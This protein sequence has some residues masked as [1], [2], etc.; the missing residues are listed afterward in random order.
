MLRGEAL[1]SVVGF[2]FPPPPP[3]PPPTRVCFSSNHS[4]SAVASPLHHSTRVAYGF[5]ITMRARIGDYVLLETIGSGAFANVRHGIHEVSGKHYAIKVMDKAHIRNHEL[6]LN[7]RRE[8]AIMKALNHP[9]IVALHQV[10]SS[11]TKL[12]IVLDLVQ[13]RELFEIISRQGTNGLP[14]QQA[15]AYFQQLIEAVDYCHSRGV[16]HRD[17]KPENLLIDQI[18]KLKV[19]DFGFSS[20][21]GANTASDLLS[22][23]CGTPHYI[24][25]EIISNAHPTY[26]GQKVDAWACGIILYALLVGYLPFDETDLTYLFR[27]IQRAYVEYP[28]WVSLSARHLIS[29]LLCV[30]PQARLSVHQVKRHPWFLVDYHPPTNPSPRSTPSPRRRRPRV[31]SNADHAAAFSSPLTVPSHPH[32]SRKTDPL[33]ALAPPQLQLPQLELPLASAGV[34]WDAA[35]SS[36]RAVTMARNEMIKSGR[37]MTSARKYSLLRKGVVNYGQLEIGVASFSGPNTLGGEEQARI[38]GILSS[39]TFGSVLGGLS[40]TAHHSSSSIASCDDVSLPVIPYADE[41][42]L[43]YQGT[44]FALEQNLQTPITVSNTTLPPDDE[45]QGNVQQEQDAKRSELVDSTL[46]ALRRLRVGLQKDALRS[47]GEQQASG[48]EKQS[49][50]SAVQTLQSEEM[51]RLLDVWETRIISDTPRTVSDG[52]ALSEEEVR[53]FQSLLRKWETFLNGQ[54]VV[55]DVSIPGSERVEDEV[56]TQSVPDRFKEEH[57]ILSNMD[58]RMRTPEESPSS[59][60]TRNTHHARWSVDTPGSKRS[61]KWNLPDGRDRNSWDCRVESSA[62]PSAKQYDDLTDK[63]NQVLVAN[64]SDLGSVPAKVDIDSVSSTRGLKSFAME[65]EDSPVTDVRSSGDRKHVEFLE[66]STSQVSEVG[67]HGTPNNGNSRHSTCDCGSPKQSTIR[68]VSSRRNKFTRQSVDNGALGRGTNPPSL[69]VLSVSVDAERHESPRHFYRSEG[70]RRIKTEGLPEPTNTDSYGWEP[71]TRSSLDKFFRR[72]SRRSSR[73]ERRLGGGWQIRTR[74]RIFTKL[75]NLQFRSKFEGRFECALG[76]E[77]C[78]RK[79]QKLLDEMGVDVHKKRGQLMLQVDLHHP[80]G[81]VAVAGIFDFQA[82]PNHEE[83]VV[84]FK[85]KDRE[86]VVSRGKEA[87]VLSE[88]FDQALDWFSSSY[89]N[90]LLYP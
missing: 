66:L 70:Q 49:T 80:S 81:N 24:A 51:I 31:S 26:D 38:R 9:N 30:D 67:T 33:P 85:R 48:A 87:F 12:Y 44:T 90:V 29:S 89:P 54:N 76:P 15:R 20:M 16:C 5:Y 68:H 82:R 63:W 56:P 57:E 58:Y 34:P 32:T 62:R 28:S 77:Q 6:T 64:T 88:F 25:P 36:A 17:L 23:Q 79:M 14:E 3:P 43:D 22:T 71:T 27:V 45:E 72:G 18:G 47:L 10:L 74:N 4:F 61:V 1:T 2:A 50:D 40:T 11:T 59:L 55:E 13:G 73:P 84:H 35:Q 75:R 39:S 69:R 42:Q 83:C 65:L 86:R 41:Q 8:I 52:T 19:T 60:H 7:V 78:L 21:K 37:P 46:H 53:A